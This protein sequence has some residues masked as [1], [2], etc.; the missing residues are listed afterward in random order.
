MRCCEKHA[1]GVLSA[2]AF[3]YHS[4]LYMKSM[5]CSVVCL[6]YGLFP[7]PP[8]KG[9]TRSQAEIPRTCLLP[10]FAVGAVCV[11]FRVEKE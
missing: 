7:P 5:L 1:W 6:C 11:L 10:P 2:T 4:L 3:L 9:V 8:P